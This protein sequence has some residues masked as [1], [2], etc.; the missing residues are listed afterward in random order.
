MYAFVIRSVAIEVAGIP[1]S[2]SEGDAWDASDPVV[3]AYP[4]LFSAEPKNV[5]RS[6]PTGKPARKSTKSTLVS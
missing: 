4:D 6:A 5:K 3:K 2:I 1:V